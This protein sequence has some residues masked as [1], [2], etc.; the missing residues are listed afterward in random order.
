MSV[1]DTNI[2]YRSIP[3]LPGHYRIGSDGSV[4]SCAAS[5]IERNSA[6]RIIRSFY[7]AGPTW[8]QLRPRV[9]AGR[10]LQ[11]KLGGK[12]YYVHCL[13]LLA[14]VGPC[15]AGRQA[16]HFPDPTPTNNNLSNLC[17]G[18]AS[19]NYADRV[20][21][22]THNKGERHGNAKLTERTVRAIRRQA[23]AGVDLWTLADKYG[24]CISSIRQIVRR[25]SWRH[26]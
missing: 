15:P 5:R 16:R 2:T 7:V 19:E 22:G 17:W 24:V 14:F 1:F 13:V 8:R 11:I 10:Y 4:W 21:H 25:K 20:V 9:N 23:T 6:G 12:R 18:T 26:V 3:G